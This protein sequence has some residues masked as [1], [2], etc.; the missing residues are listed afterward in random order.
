MLGGLGFIPLDSLDPVTE[1][2]VP[3]AKRLSL[4][5]FKSQ[6]VLAISRTQ[7]GVALK[8]LYGALDRERPGAPEAVFRRLYASKPGTFP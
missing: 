5:E 2:A 7:S 3:A 6:P 4:Q 8:E 1:A